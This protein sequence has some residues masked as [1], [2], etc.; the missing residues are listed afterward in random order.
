VLAEVAGRVPLLIEIKD[1][2]GRFGPT[3]GVLEG[4][5]AAACRAIRGRPP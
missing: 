4:A 2:S 3:N 1:Q 5:T